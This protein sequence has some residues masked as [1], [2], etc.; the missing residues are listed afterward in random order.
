MNYITSKSG[1][2]LIEFRAGTEPAPLDEHPNLP[3]TFACVIAKYKGKALFVYNSWRMEWE[4]PSG[5][6]NSGEKPYEAALRELAEESGQTASTL[7]YKGLCL[8]NNY[9]NDQ[10]ELGAIY[11]CEL[12]QVE[13]FQANDES[14]K[15]M[16]WDTKVKTEEYVNEI[17]IA[18]VKL[19]DEILSGDMRY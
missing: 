17:G 4:L 1:D 8:L 12:E 16:F 18:L 6:I 11:G 2:K 15:M 5:L 14:T 7:S 19:V 10:L 13:P 9:P 3:I